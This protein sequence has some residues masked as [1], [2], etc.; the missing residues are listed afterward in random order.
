MPRAVSFTEYGGTGVLHI[1]D[2]ERPVP[3]R[4]Q[5][6]VRV[7]VAAT[8]PVDNA[9][10]EGFMAAVM[11]TEFP[12]GQG[13]E[14]AGRVAEI[15]AGVDGFQA[16]DEVFGRVV[17]TAQADYVLAQADQ[18]ALKPAGTPWEAAAS[19]PSVGATAFAAVR[20]AAPTTGETVV[21]SAAAGGVG[22][23]TTQLVLRTGA[24]VIGT[25]SEHNFEFLRGLGAEPVAYGDGL[26]DRI[27]ALAPDGV[28]AYLD[29]F[30]DGNVATALKLG[31][32]PERVNTIADYAAPERYG[33]HGDAQAQA[34]TPEIWAELAELVAEGALTVPIHAVYAL[35]DVRQ[36]YDE[37][38]KRHTRGKIVL[39]VSD[40]RQP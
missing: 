30:G 39:R 5:V 19:L 16:G 2:V 4:G 27:R 20:A 3:G 11:P 26:A 32:A 17:R 23:V 15:G 14:F 8:N 35:E 40:G 25:A 34:N 21:V 33:V 36:A 6:L 24:R 9:L 13:W 7:F 10:R 38:A 29:N 37:L 12:S 1:V 31:V 22:A 18:L 28:D